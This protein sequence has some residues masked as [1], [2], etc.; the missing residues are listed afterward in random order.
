M[1][2]NHMNTPKT[3]AVQMTGTTD[4]PRPGDYLR[5]GIQTTHDT[6]TEW[7]LAEVIYWSTA[8]DQESIRRLG[9]YLTQKWGWSDIH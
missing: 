3:I 8:L 2:T 5:C 4:W 7:C 1:T 9:V 6:R